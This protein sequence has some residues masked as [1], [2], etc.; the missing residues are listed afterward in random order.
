MAPNPKKLRIKLS[1]D[2]YARLRNRVYIKQYCCCI[3]CGKWLRFDEFSLH[4][5]ISRGAGGDDSE[6]NVDGYCVGCHPD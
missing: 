1:P 5:I 6:E 4:H 2:E 3:K